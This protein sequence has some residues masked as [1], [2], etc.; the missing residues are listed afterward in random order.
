MT[1]L[2]VD[3]QRKGGTQPFSLPA[4][5]PTRRKGGAQMEKAEEPRGHWFL[6]DEAFQA[7]EWLVSQK[8]VASL[9]EGNMRYID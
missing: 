5:T 9:L 1:T 6:Q 8:W 3:L 2:L 4:R 7:A